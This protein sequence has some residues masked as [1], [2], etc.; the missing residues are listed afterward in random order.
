MN[1]RTTLVAG[2]GLLI[3]LLLAAVALSLVRLEALGDSVERLAAQRVPK[4][5]AVGQSSQALMQASRQM[6]NALLLDSE[7]QIKTELGEI[8]A[9]SQRVSDAL[10]E[11]E[12]VLQDDVERG[13]FKDITE[14]RAAYQLS[15]IHI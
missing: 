10:Q 4:M 2:F 6:R 11:I 5:I 3:V 15:L 7:A 9:N 8:L 1:T 14:R 12:K 13:L